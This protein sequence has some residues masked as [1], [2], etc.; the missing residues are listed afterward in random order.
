MLGYSGSF[1][2]SLSLSH[3]VRAFTTARNY[4]SI[5]QPHMLHIARVNLATEATRSY[6]IKQFDVPCLQFQNGDQNDPPFLI[7]N[8]VIG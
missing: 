5:T 4:G 2:L 3:R 6:R 1:F 8:K 7:S